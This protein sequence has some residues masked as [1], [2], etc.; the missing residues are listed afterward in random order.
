MTWRCVGGSSSWPV[1]PPSPRTPPCRAA[2]PGSNR[3]FIL[4]QVLKP[5]S[6][7]MLRSS[8]RRFVCS[9][10]T[11][12]HFVP[13]ARPHRS[14]MTSVELG[15]YLLQSR[16]HCVHVVRNFLLPTPPLVRLV[17]Q[18]HWDDVCSRFLSVQLVVEG[19]SPC[20]RSRHAIHELHVE[21]LQNLFVLLR[22]LRLVQAC[23]GQIQTPSHP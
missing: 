3:C 17:C 11:L 1:G 7:L 23:V 14:S 19:W 4:C 6:S 12:P 10:I 2:C 8:L 18:V 16:G 22:Q 20:S 15:K 21:V 9:S 5:S 13:R